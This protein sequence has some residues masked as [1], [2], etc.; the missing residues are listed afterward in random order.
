M[1]LELLKAAQEGDE[2]QVKLLLDKG[3]KLMSRIGTAGH[4]S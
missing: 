2:Q 4:R 1:S 3:E